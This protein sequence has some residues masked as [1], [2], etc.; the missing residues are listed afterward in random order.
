[1]YLPK[2]VLEN[3]RYWFSAVEMLQSY[4]ENFASIFGQKNI[5]FSL[6]ALLH[7]S[8]CVAQFGPLYSFSCYAFENYMQEI[9]GYF[10]NAQNILQQL[11]NRIDEEL[12]AGRNDEGIPKQVAG[13]KKM[14]KVPHDGFEMTSSE[15]NT[16][17]FTLRNSTRDQN[18][19]LADCAFFVID[20]F[21]HSD[22]VDMAVGRS[23]SRIEPYFTE[24]VNS[25]EKLGIVLASNLLEQQFAVPYSTLQTKCMKYPKFPVKTGKYEGKYEDSSE[26]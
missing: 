13:F 24:P 18:C 15:C 4:V 23:D 21:G 19:L 11:F 14:H 8:E 1:L 5:T 10:R 20:F 9:K 6:H 7:L 17:K 22:N 3:N 25:Q 16:S 2:Q 12:I 26:H